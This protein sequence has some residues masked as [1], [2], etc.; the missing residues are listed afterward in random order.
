MPAYEKYYTSSDCTVF[1]EHAEGLTE[2]VLLDKLATVGFKEDLNS[3]P[4]YG[5]G[6]S[7]FGF[8]SQG[9]LIINGVLQFNFVHPNYLYTTLKYLQD[10]GKVVEEGISAETL[11]SFAAKQSEE[12]RANRAALK[13]ALKK[14]N[15]KFGLSILDYPSNFNIR[16]V[17]NNGFLYDSDT[18]KV[19]LLKG[20][21][22]T[23][24]Q[25]SVASAS[26]DPID[27][28]YMFLARE[29]TR[30]TI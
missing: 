27:Q 28:T 13:E 20:V 22:I 12:L 11:E 3:Q 14:N 6:N 21:K 19:V 26:D 29:I 23:G 18:D 24:K 5:I 16:I 25:Q 30:E 1:I 10:G 9:N 8:L 17:F 15:L 4:V 7:K 2:P